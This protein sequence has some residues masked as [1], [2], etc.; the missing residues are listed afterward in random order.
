MTSQIKYSNFL[1]DKENSAL[2]KKFKVQVKEEMFFLF[3]SELEYLL[4]LSAEGLMKIRLQLCA[5]SSL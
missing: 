5:E 4:S 1:P 2:S 3:Q